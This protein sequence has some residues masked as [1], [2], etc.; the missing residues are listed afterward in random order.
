MKTYQKFSTRAAIIVTGLVVFIGVAGYYVVTE[1]TSP[2]AS[3]TNSSSSSVSLPPDTFL[4]PDPRSDPILTPAP[5][6]P[7]QTG[8]LSIHSLLLSSGSIGDLVTIRGSGF[9]TTQNI[10]RFSGDYSRYLDSSDGVTLTFTIPAELDNCHPSG[11]PCNE[12][13]SVPVTA[14]KFDVYVT[15]VNGESNILTFSVT[16]Q[17]DDNQSS[18]NLTEILEELNDF[19]EEPC[20]TP[21]GRYHTVKFDYIRTND[22]GIPIIQYP[23]TNIDTVHMMTDKVQEKMSALEP[24]TPVEVYFYEVIVFAPTSGAYSAANE[25]IQCFNLIS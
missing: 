13:Q 6:P 16:D 10:V 21:P 17:S 4:S 19:P 12:E 5:N 25:T 24:N 9:T 3:S 8:P 23:G 14:G 18:L 1:F 22:A 11:N 20:P 2:P 7:D 15:N